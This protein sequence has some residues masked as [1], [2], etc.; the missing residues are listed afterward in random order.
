MA[1]ARSSTYA[2]L[3]AATICPAQVT[4]SEYPIPT[5]SSYLNEGIVKGP[6]GN[7]WFIEGNGIKIARMTTLGVVTG[8][9]PIPST[10]IYGNGSG[11]GSITTGPDGNLWFT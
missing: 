8:Q 2:L 4:F 10:G 11:A 9:F 1:N 3:M 6:D 7:L 5:S